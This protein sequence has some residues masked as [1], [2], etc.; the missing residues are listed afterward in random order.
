MGIE[1]LD[2]IKYI[3]TDSG[4]RLTDVFSFCVIF[5]FYTNIADSS[6]KVFLGSRI[7]N[8]LESEQIKNLDFEIS[9]SHLKYIKC[10]DQMKGA[11][12]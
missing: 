7:S 10:L 9:R 8:Q 3:I 5:S 6:V 2:L 12:H 1:S 11:Q 4:F